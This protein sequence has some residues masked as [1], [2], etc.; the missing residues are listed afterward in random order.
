MDVLK[1]LLRTAVALVC[2]GAPGTAIVTAQQTIEPD[3][4]ATFLY[5]FTR[6]IEWPGP[7]PGSSAPF[8]ICVIADASMEQAIKRTVEGE[9]VHGRPLVMTQPQNVQDV[10]A[11]QILFV[12]RSEHQRGA[13]LLAAVRDLPVLTVGDSPHFVDRGGAIQF[14]LVE[15]RVRFDINLASAQ[16]AQLKVSANLLRVA[17][18]VEPI[19]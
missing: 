13:A 3:V 11:C 17:R 18:K 15:N 16:R 2:L 8:R 19:R 4:K 1:Q 10:E 9:V 5:N 7:P 12:G 14:V 6:F